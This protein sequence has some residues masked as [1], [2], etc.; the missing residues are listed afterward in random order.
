MN[1]H[2]F[3]LL[4]ICL[5]IF[6][7]STALGATPTPT[8]AELIFSE[9][10]S[11]SFI[12]Q[13]ERPGYWTSSATGSVNTWSVQSSAIPI[14]DKAFVGIGDAPWEGVW[15]TETIDTGS[16]QSAEISIDVYGD[17]ALGVAD[18]YVEFF[19]QTDGEGVSSEAFSS[20]FSSI[21]SGSGLAFS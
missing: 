20:S 6:I 10:F 5:I 17:I 16:Y 19:F 8:P 9:S 14:E 13:T 12:G 21:F 4:W 18:S 11:T 2:I 7:G 15:S 1:K 3:Y